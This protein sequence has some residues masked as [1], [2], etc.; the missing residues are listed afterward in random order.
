M[1]LGINLVLKAYDHQNRKSM[2]GGKIISR[3]KFNLNKV[4]GQK[5]KI[6]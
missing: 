5:D 4:E 6:Q 3:F 2:I 1:L